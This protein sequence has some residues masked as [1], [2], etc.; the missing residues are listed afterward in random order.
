MEE[1]I[2]RGGM[3]C[4]R[5][6]RAAWGEKKGVGEGRMWQSSLS[7]RTLDGQLPVTG[8]NRQNEEGG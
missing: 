5:Y 3:P 6:R 8:Y 1:K 2:N 7:H 4:Q